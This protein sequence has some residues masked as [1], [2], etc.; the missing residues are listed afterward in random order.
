MWRPGFAHEDA[1]RAHLTGYHRRLC[2]WSWDHRGSRQTPGLVFG[3]DRGGSCVGRVFRVADRDTESVMA[4]LWERELVYDV[5]RPQWLPVRLDDGRRV[6]ALTFVVQRRTTQYAGRLDAGAAAAVIA[7][8]HGRSGPN[9]DYVLNTLSQL[10][11]LGIHDPHLEAIA[12]RLQGTAD[13]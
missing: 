12:S 8:A 1:A 2:V 7:G 5:Y 9:R 3:L 4:Y 11:T 13:T 10:K 6:R